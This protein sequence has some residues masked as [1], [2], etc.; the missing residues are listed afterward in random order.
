VRKQIIFYGV[1]MNQK[2]IKYISL[3][4]IPRSP[5]QVRVGPPFPHSF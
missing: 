5:V 2:P 1:V 3:N 4:L